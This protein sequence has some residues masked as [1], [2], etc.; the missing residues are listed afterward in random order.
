MIE[1]EKSG[2]KNLIHLKIKISK[3][4]LTDE[5]TETLKKYPIE[6]VRKYVKLIH[7]SLL[8]KGTT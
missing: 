2:Y 1:E 4:G 5:N 3:Q 6:A 7:G 8:S